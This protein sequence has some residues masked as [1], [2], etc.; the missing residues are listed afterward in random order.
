MAG[1]PLARLLAGAVPGPSDAAT[2]ELRRRVGRRLCGEPLQH[3]LGRWSFRRLELRVDGRALVPRPETEVVAGEALAALAARDVAGGGRRN[4]PPVAVDLGTGSGAI[5]CALVDEHPTVR[6]VAVEVAEE[7]RT[8]A[9]ENRATLPPAAATRLEVRAGSWYEPL[10]DL[11]GAVDV[12]VSNPPY[13]AAAEWP[14]LDAVVREF[15]PYGALVAGPTGL[16]GI[17]AVL[18]GAPGVLAPGGAVVVELAPDQAGAAV[19]LARCQ[20]ARA[21]EVR[22]D[23]AG[24][25]RCLV[26]RW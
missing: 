11:A 12:V 3:V 10:A 4:G 18:A 9:E 21:A 15:D 23:L 26:A 2:A 25:P 24:R 16:E 1:Q 17:E 5:A 8:L 7:A 13:L 20:G 14:A 22:P 19:E 6:V